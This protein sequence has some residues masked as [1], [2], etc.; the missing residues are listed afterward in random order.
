MKSNTPNARFWVWEN[1]GWIKLTLKPGQTLRWVSG[2]STDEGYSNDYH[3]WEYDT[4]EGVVIADYANESR[5][6]DGRHSYH[7][8]SNCL[9]GDLQALP[10]V[11]ADPENYVDEIPVPRP[12]WR[13]GASSQRD[14][15]AEAMGY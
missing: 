11:T 7:A 4:E 1:D 12:D 3:S 5:D 10:P 13:R 6:C 9:I 15:Y 2:G 14:H 8:T